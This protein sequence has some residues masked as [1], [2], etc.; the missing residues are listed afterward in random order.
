MKEESGQKGQQIN[1]PGIGTQFERATKRVINPDGSYNIHRKGVRH[2]IRDIFRYLTEIP[3]PK[4][5]LLLF[6]GYVVINVF[7]TIIYLICGFENIAG[8][9]PKNGNVYFQAFFFSIQ[10]FT[11]VGY[12][13]L[14]PLGVATQTV[15]AIEAF[16]GFMSFSLATGLLYGRFSRPTSR[17]VFS[18]HILYSKHKD[19]YSFKLKLANERD[20]VLLEAEAKIIATFDEVDEKGDITKR[21][22]RPVLEID[23]IDLM[24]FTWTLVHYID[25]DSPFFGMDK[26]DLLKANVEFLIMFK[27]YSEVFG[28]Y[29][30]TRKSYTEEDIIWNKNFRKIFNPNAHGIIELDIREINDLIDE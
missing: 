26:D 25:N 21:Y 6:C 28:T 23:H 13:T 1:D 18:D 30:H 17:I 4:F 8:I 29:I 12:G 20:T 16:V 10:T 3:W 19:G 11:T 27:A 15:A 14:A 5:F 22:F 7:F 2:G 24:P 9:D